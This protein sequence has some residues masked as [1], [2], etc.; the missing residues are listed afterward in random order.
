MTHHRYRFANATHP[1]VGMAPPSAT[2]SRFRYVARVDINRDT[3]DTKDK[4]VT[5][6]GDGGS[7][8][9]HAGSAPSTSWETRETRNPP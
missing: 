3:K 9:P 5:W 4:L 2:G 1:G 8:D 6:E 7:L